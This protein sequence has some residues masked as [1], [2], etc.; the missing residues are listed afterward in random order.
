M[1]LNWDTNTFYPVDRLLKWRYQVSDKGRLIREF[2]VKWKFHPHQYNSWEQY[3]H[4]DA[5]TRAEADKLVQ[6]KGKEVR[7]A[8]KVSMYRWTNHNQG[9]GLLNPKNRNQ[10]EAK[11]PRKRGTRRPR[12][13]YY[14][15]WRGHP[16]ED[17]EWL[18][19]AH[20]KRM[21]GEA[22]WKA[23]LLNQCAPDIVKIE[24]IEVTEL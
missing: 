23:K 11:C 17:G 18:S 8:E 10:K 12:K 20:V 6:K 15:E 19:T 2:L 3:H 16:E 1:K 13:E 24:P 21:K 4:L 14:I 22:W 5:K 9:Q 7:V